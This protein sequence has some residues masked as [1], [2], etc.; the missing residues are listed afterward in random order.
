M[1]KLHPLS[2][3]LICMVLS[4]LVFACGNLYILCMLLGISLL[5]S[6]LRKA[7]GIK[8]SLLSLWKSLPFVLS[9]A[10]IQLIFR[11][12]GTMLWS[13]GILGIS[14][15]ALYW[16]GLISLRFFTVILCAKALSRC[17]YPEFQAAFA[18]LRLPE[19][20]AFM[21]SYGVQLIPAFG[22]MLKGFM[23]SLRLRGIE[24]AKL[25][26]SK[27]LQVYRTL[28]ISA[29]A[30]II[31]NS[32]SSAIALELRGFR[33]HGKRSYLHKQSV[34]LADACIFAGLILLIYFSLA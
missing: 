17:S 22:N 29:I 16:A 24:P 3:I 19:E 20:F 6:A 4:S 8:K 18:T 7:Y 9:L 21:I 15:G 33:S 10:V 5:Y 27:R 2:H 28:A 32:H 26:W 30:G 13:Y 14:G 1:I 34:G 23:R 11:R 31:S 12:E 25:P